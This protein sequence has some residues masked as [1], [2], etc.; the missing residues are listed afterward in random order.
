MASSNSFSNTEVA[1]LCATGLAGL[2]GEA[3]TFESA[4]GA[5]QDLEVVN[6]VFR[7]SQE[8]IGAAAQQDLTRWGALASSLLLLQNK[9]E[10][11]KVVEAFRSQAP[12]EECI[13]ILES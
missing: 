11:E 12:L 3:M 1:A 10:Y 6:Q 13:S 7:N 9:P 4:R 5:D 8:F 2:V